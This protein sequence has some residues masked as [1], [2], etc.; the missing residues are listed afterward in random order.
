MIQILLADDHKVVRKGLRRTLEEQAG[1]I[2]C[3]EAAN[4]REAVEL[5]VRLKPDIV[6]LDLSMPELGGIEATRHIKQSLPA[7]EILIFSMHD[8]AEIILS[9]FE[10]GARGFLLKSDEDFRLF[11]AVETISQHKPFLTT[12]ASEAL[13]GNLLRPAVKESVLSDREREVVQLLSKGKSN[14]QVATALGISVKTVESH[15]AAV[16][17]K[18]EIGSLAELVRYAVRTRLIEA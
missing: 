9:A 1:W 10:A 6:I 11:E 18:L 14:K 2:V 13:L 5:A 3:G 8:S 16:M 17:R 12:A 4:G 15:R 7:T